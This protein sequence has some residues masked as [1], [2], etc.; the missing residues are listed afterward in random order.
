VPEEHHGEHGH[1]DQRDEHGGHGRDGAHDRDVV[2][3]PLADFLATVM[4]VVV[5]TVRKDGT[6]QLN[7]AWYEYRDGLIWL[8]SAESRAWAKRC[9]PD[10]RITLLFVDPEDM[11]HWA[12]V[13]GTVLERTTKG[14]E[15]HIDRLAHRYLGSDYPRHDAHDPRVV[16]TVRP[17]RVTGFR[18]RG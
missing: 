17:T 13:Q 15:E 14:G 7:P 9:T 2:G 12:Q 3:A 5:G 11:F 16:V 4:P 18:D 8:N 6:A 1:H 10:A